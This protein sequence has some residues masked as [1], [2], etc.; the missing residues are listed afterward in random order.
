[1]FIGADDLAG[2]F[3]SESEA[4]DSNRLGGSRPQERTAGG[5]PPVPTVSLP[6]FKHETG[7][8]WSID[9]CHRAVYKSK[10]DLVILCNSRYGNGQIIDSSDGGL[11]WTLRDATNITGIDQKFIPF[12]D[13]LMSPDNSDELLLVAG[14]L[15]MNSSKGM[16]RSTDGGKTFSLVRDTPPGGFVGSFWGAPR[17]LE[18]DA[19]NA[20]VRYWSIQT[21]GTAVWK[22]AD[23][24]LHWGACGGISETG[25]AMFVPGSRTGNSPA[26]FGWAAAQ[27]AGYLQGNAP[28]LYRTLDF[29]ETFSPVVPVATVP[30]EPGVLYNLT[31]PSQHGPL[32]DA[33]GDTVVVFASG[34]NVETGE[35]REMTVWASVD[36]GKSFAETVAPGS[37]QWMSRINELRVDPVYTSRVWVTTA[38]RSAQIIDLV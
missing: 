6:F 12:D 18:N 32:V 38:G 24:G 37:A 33:E 11:S 15:F 25:M 23:R 3:L 30:S 26:G 10:N 20:S 19:G 31:I 35:S 1:M 29:C 9:Y 13:L 14:Y 22:S 5:R 27:T 28:A 8:P 36:G 34:V 2:F 21:H 4:A 17:Q 16:Y 7:G